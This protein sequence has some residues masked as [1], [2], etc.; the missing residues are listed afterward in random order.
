MTTG[1]VGQAPVESLS[2]R[3]PGSFPRRFH[4]ETQSAV[5]ASVLDC[6]FTA[7]SKAFANSA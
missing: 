3:G 2:L 1:D 4:M 6:S 5:T 7:S